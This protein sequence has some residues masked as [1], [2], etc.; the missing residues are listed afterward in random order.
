MLILV[1]TGVLL[2]GFRRDAPEQTAILQACR[3]LWK[4]G[5]ELV[6]SVQNIAEFWN[7]STRPAAARGGLGLSVAVTAR[8]LRFIEAMG[9]VLSFT[10]KAY[11]EWKKLLLSHQ[12]IGASVHDARLVATMMDKKIRHLLTLNVADFKRYAGIVALT[13]QEALTAVIR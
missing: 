9:Q 1:D 7:V 3:R 8:R 2:R 6:T 10:A 5:H 4:E 11:G 12:I 13:P